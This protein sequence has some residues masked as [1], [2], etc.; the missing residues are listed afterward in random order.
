MPPFSL[1]SGGSGPRLT[2]VSVDIIYFLVGPHPHSLM[3]LSASFVALA[4]RHSRWR[5]SLS[6]GAPPPLADAVVC[7]LRCACRPAWP[8]APLLTSII[9]RGHGALFRPTRDARRRR[10]SRA[11]SSWDVRRH[12]RERRTTRRPCVPRL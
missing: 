5:N 7:K 6:R 10:H 12:G 4:D 9:R 1:M 3:P 11:T 8:Q 2:D